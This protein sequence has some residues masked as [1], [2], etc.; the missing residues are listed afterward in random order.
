MSKAFISSVLGLS[1]L[2]F[3]STSCND[4]AFSRNG[5]QAPLSEDSSSP[6]AY[7]GPGIAEEGIVGGHF[8]L[9]TSHLVYAPSAG[10]TDH[11]VH[12]YDDK[13]QT[14]GADF[15]NLL[16][17][18]L[19]EIQTVIP[20]QKRFILIISNAE[21][22]TGGRLEING[23]SQNVLTFQNQGRGLIAN[24]ASPQAYTIGTP[25]KAGDLKLSALKIYF[26][27]DVIA[28]NGLVPT[29]TGCVRKNQPGA[30][31]E[32]RDGALIIQ[33]LDADLNKIDP[34]TGVASATGGG[35]LWEATI[36]WHRD[37]TCY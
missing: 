18:G 30:K 3:M 22:S 26:D 6:P 20:A 36:F 21:L 28:Q 5:A 31:G 9:D 27:K 29:E 7:Q 12:Q 15:F 14:N 23:S 25:T 32:Y 17:A 8:D 1:T 33:A 2:V 16:E 24:G 37:G 35:L 11:H 10:T 13:Y 19:G 34:A 4:S